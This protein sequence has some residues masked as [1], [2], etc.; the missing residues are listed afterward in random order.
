MLRHPGN[1]NLNL[2]F[3]PTFAGRP[4]LVSSA[5]FIREY[6]HRLDETIKKSIEQYS[7][8]FAFRVDLRLPA[9]TQLPACAYTNQVI[10]RFI[11]SFKAKIR[12]N[13]RMALISNPKAH[14]SEVRYVWA[15]ELGQH[16]LPHYHLVILLNRD[17][18]KVLGSINSESDNIIHRLQS[19]WASALG[20]P[21]EDIRGTVHIPANADYFLD[22]GQPEG[23][24][25]LFKRA[26]YICKAATKFFGDGQHGFGS[27]RI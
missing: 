6:L 4:L 1:T 21:G 13:R 16:G 15:R 26:S 11:G 19:A 27:S 22:R 10:D 17:A 7:R 12:H 25:E 24:D 18:Y 2:Y 14:A 9:N 20:L 8:V 3:A 23:Q 5:P